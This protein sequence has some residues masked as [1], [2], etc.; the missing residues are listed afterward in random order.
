MDDAKTPT[1][2]DGPEP[3]E[4]MSTQ[5]A[6]AEHADRA[7]GGPSGP[8]NE[9]PPEG[10]TGQADPADE[11]KPEPIDRGPEGIAADAHAAPEVLVE[12]DAHERRRNQSERERM[13]G[14]KAS[15]GPLTASVG[16]GSIRAGQVSGTIHNN[17]YGARESMARIGAHVGSVTK[18]RV[19]AEVEAYVAVR[20][21]DEIVRTLQ[22]HGVVYLMGSAR[23]GREATALTAL[24][25][26]VGPDKVRS[27]YLD[28]GA[29][30]SAVIEHDD[31]PNARHGHF[32][33]V[34]PNQPVDS[35]TLAVIGGRFRDAGSFLVV[36]GPPARRVDDE[37]RPYAAGH[38]APDSTQVLERHLTAQFQLRMRCVGN[39]ATCDGDCFVEFVHRCLDDIEIGTYLG[40]RPL[41]G[42]VVS[43]TRQLV[44]TA[45]DG[46]E[47][48]AALELIG[49]RLRHLAG[50][51]LKPD[52]GSEPAH[53]LRRT[54]YRIAY[55]TFDGSPLSVV[56]D[57][58][59]SLFDTLT[60][61]NPD[62]DEATAGG[63]FEG[64]L[65][66]LLDPDMYRHA[67]SG[68]D[69]TTDAERKAKLVDPALASAMLD[70]AWN[71]YDR[72]REPLLE[73]LGALGGDHRDRVRMRAAYSA[74]RLATYDFGV[75]YHGLIRKWATSKS[76]HFRQSAAMA[77]EFAAEDS[78]Y[79][80]RVRRQVRD[81]A[82]AKNP[83]LNDSAARAYS[84]DLGRLFFDDVLTNLGFI[85]EEAVQ[86]GSN[87]IAQAINSVFGTETAAFVVETL[88]AWVQE[89]SRS[90]RVQ[91]AK[92]LLFLMFRK[93]DKPN[94]AWP[95]LLLLARDERAAS[96]QLAGLWRHALSDAVIALG[97]WDALRL[98]GVKVDS[99]DEPASVYASVTTD[100]LSAEPLR[101]RALSFYLPMWR[102]K[103]SGLSVFP[104]LE[105]AIRKA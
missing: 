99:H 61:L 97:A 52:P 22:A 53:E 60:Q 23:S 86:T 79:T 93:A 34:G 44:E 17:Y 31:L 70:V 46:R 27:I 66:S 2:P 32:V 72:N 30:I 41:P 54:A 100:A 14:D 37:L 6:G 5:E 38:D 35:A 95:A 7:T 105:D 1:T 43:L 68:S 88:S 25:G 19:D 33:K 63:P 94:D 20:Q 59:S 96:E 64:R 11:P 45:I 39:C 56:S 77:L 62:G 10:E 67:E 26:L 58:A 12:R 29:S 8:D 36:I 18:D 28:E 101:T 90:L 80:G 78:A 69:S 91:A 89:E 50:E 51:L 40:K 87:A 42:D 98:W 21:Y 13:R 9:Q 81:W 73:W 103:H 15:M 47:P 82:L 55:A 83:Y 49:S 84:T 102:A 104:R 85:A 74:G 57:A 71:D 48:A 65:E 24:A 3:A 16:A 75:V 4:P 76:A 92:T